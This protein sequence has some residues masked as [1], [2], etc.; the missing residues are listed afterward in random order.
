MRIA[1]AGIA[2]ATNWICNYAVVLVTPIALESISWRYYVV[3][4]VLNV[5]FIPI[6]GFFVSACF[7]NRTLQLLIDAIVCRN[8]GSLLG[9]N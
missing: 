6:V 9:A 2:T 1:G 8:E 7:L 5:C 4:A 3:Y